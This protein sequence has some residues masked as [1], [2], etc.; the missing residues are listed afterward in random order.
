MPQAD[1]LGALRAARG[2]AADVAAAQRRLA[3]R[4]GRPKRSVPSIR[5]DP[6]ALHNAARCVR[7]PFPVFMWLEG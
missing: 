3:Q 2:A 6:A 5:A 4:A 7:A 1:V